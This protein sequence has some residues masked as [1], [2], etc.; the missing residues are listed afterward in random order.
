MMK[1]LQAHTKQHQASQDAQS[2]FHDITHSFLEMVVEEALTSGV[3]PRKLVNACTM[4][5]MM[6][7]IPPTGPGLGCN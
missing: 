3:K 5:L 2:S 6:E 4:M 1:P 7:L